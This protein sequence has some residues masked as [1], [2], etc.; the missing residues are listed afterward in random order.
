[1]S[2]Y[3]IPWSPSVGVPVATFLVEDG[4]CIVR[5]G[6]H[7]VQAVS[8]PVAHTL[9]VLDM[10]DGVIS[11]E[12]MEM[13]VGDDNGRFVVE[14]RTTHTFGPIHYQLT[15]YGTWLPIGAFP[16]IGTRSSVEGLRGLLEGLYRRI[17]PP[18][19]MSPLEATLWGHRAR[20][21]PHMP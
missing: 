5:F 8:W 18:T 14:R 9:D 2:G 11:G 15:A 7:T 17:P 20:S 21:S 6:R 10:L 12:E 13:G 1:M 19:R 4:T 16:L 3:E